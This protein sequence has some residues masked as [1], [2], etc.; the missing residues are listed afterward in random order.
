MTDY[1]TRE[2]LAMDDHSFHQAVAEDLVKTSNYQG[3]FQDRGVIDRTMGALVDWL[4]ITTEKLNDRAEDPTCP[5]VLYEKT[6]KFRRHLLTVIDNTDRRMAWQ[7]GAKEREVRRWKQVLFEVIDAIQE[8]WDDDEI[9]AMT[10]PS[11]GDGE[12]SFDL[13]TWHEIRLAKR[14]DRKRAERTEAAA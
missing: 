12:E 13:E 8:G 4:Q 14:P 11:W 1:N 3:P 2:L 5:P 6:A 7:Q 10:V 9:L